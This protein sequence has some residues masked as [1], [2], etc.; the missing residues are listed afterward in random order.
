[1]SPALATRGSQ[2]TRTDRDPHIRFTALTE[3]VRRANIPKM[4]PFGHRREP[5][6]EQ[7]PT[8]VCCS[9]QPSVL[10]PGT[11]L[12]RQSYII[13]LD[14]MIEHDSFRSHHLSRMN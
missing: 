14:V 8:V 6:V 5:V 7:R 9:Q 3:L 12:P 10:Q 13:V 11:R 1:M 2:V 4:I